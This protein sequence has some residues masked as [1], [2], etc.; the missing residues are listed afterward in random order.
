MGSIDK[1][2][3][4]PI[5]NIEGS[6]SHVVNQ[7]ANKLSKEH[8]VPIVHIESE[9]I[10]AWRWHL[11]HQSAGLWDCSHFCCDNEVWDI[12]HHGL[13]TAEEMHLDN[14]AEDIY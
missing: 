6:A 14:E 1:T 5:T 2:K 3:C 13:V 11:Y 10:D 12:F 8:D 9:L 4:G 7:I